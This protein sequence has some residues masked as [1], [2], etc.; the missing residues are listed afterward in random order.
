MPI[1]SAMM[2]SELTHANISDDAKSPALSLIQGMLRYEPSDRPTVQFT[3][4]HVFFKKRGRRF[5]PDRMC[6]KK[7][8]S[9]GNA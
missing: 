5:H 1:F 3:C 9:D 7:M 4:E 8:D 2:E 6:E